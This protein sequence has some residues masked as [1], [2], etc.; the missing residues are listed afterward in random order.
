[1]LDQNGNVAFEVFHS[2]YY[3]KIS[4][5]LNRPESSTP[6]PD[7]QTTTTEH[8]HDSEEH[9]HEEHEH[10]HEH[11]HEE[12]HEEQHTQPETNV[13]ENKYDEETQKLIDQSNEA[14][15][16]FEKSENELRNIENEIADLSKKLN[17]DVG[18]NAEFATMIDKCFEY[19]DRE[20]VYKLCPFEKTV[21]RSKNN[22]GETT[23]GYWKGWSEDEKNKYNVMKFDNGLA[24]WNG[25]SRSTLVHV[26]CGIENKVTS[27]AEP[28]RCEVII[29]FMNK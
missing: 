25:P 21:Q 6:I 28:N 27:V 9:S 15:S 24:C 22:Q 14:K 3:E 5:H 26:T 11:D 18:P 2:L 20:Y 4:P 10:D 7:Q 8:S 29:K 1:M 12:H 19:E 17:Y 23:I 16:V 13:S